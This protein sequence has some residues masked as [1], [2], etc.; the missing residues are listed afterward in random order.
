MLEKDITMQRNSKSPK[1]L[2]IFNT[3]DEDDKDIA[4]AMSESLAI[5]HKNNM[6]IT[7]RNIVIDKSR[8]EDCAKLEKYHRS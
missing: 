3:L 2:A 4:I 7:I 6:A 5:K 8:K 1:L